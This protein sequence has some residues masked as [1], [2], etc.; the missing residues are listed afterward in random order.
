[1]GKGMWRN[2]EGYIEDIWERCVGKGMWRNREGY[3]E[4][5]WERCLGKSM[6]RRGVWGRV[7][8]QWGRICGVRV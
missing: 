3:I 8:A 5:V 2:R 1:M 7:C 4:D 6:W